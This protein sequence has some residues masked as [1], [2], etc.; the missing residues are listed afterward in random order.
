MIT[1]ADAVLTMTQP[2][3]FPNPVQLQNF[4]T[5][6]IYD[7]DAIRTLEAMMGVDG[8]L[9]FGFVFVPVLQNYTF[10]ADSPSVTSFFDIVY[11][12]QRAAKTTYPLSGVIRLPSLGKK[13]IMTNGGLSNY[14][15]APDA[16]RVLQVQ[17][18]QITWESVVPAPA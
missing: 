9:S 15:V 18:F 10:M 13:Y 1:S 4:G 6:D 11:T 7:T 16:K 17:K 8:N 5:D 3:L 12:Q 14:K 2:T